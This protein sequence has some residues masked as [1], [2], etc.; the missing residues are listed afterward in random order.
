[1]R[2]SKVPAS[3]AKAASTISCCFAQI[4]NLFAVL[5]IESSAHSSSLRLG[6]RTAL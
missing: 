1:M 5:E 6:R 4:E 3:K 2:R